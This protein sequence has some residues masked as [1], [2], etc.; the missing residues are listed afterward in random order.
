M[1]RDDGKLDRHRCDVLRLRAA[2]PVPRNG[3]GQQ[4]YLLRSQKT[5]QP[6]ITGYELQIWDYQPA[7][8]NTGS[9]VQTVKAPATKILGDQWNSYEVT[10]EGDRFLI[11]LNGE[12]LL[13]TRDSKHASGVIG[14]QCQPNNPIQF[15]NIK[16]LRQKK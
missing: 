6:H 3:E 10:S 4:R 16:L 5:G 7:G 9:L 12:K 14:L 11:V 15:R 1:R 8:Y 13:D 2:D